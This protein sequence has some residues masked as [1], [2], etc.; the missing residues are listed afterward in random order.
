MKKSLSIL[1]L[2]FSVFC[3]SPAVADCYDDAGEY[4]Q[5]NH[6]VLR[7][8]A[9][10]ESG[11]NPKLIHKNSNSS[12]DFGLTGIN[13]IHLNNLSKFGITERELLDGC[14]SIYVRGWLY[15]QKMAKYGNTWEAVGATHSET[16]RYR[17]A[18]IA[19]IQKILRK[20]QIIL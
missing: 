9:Q 3:A 5:V 18:Y 8:F 7:A 15:R 10:Q 11:N 14:V 19:A 1:T 2:A 6:W 16:P 12:L 17:D 13:S 4:H 20:W